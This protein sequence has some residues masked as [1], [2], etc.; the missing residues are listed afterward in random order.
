[1]ERLWVAKVLTSI[2]LLQAGIANADIYNSSY[3][4][5]EAFASV[6][7]QPTPPY[8]GTARIATITRQKNGEIYVL[9]LAKAIPL[10]QLK[11]KPSAGRLKIYGA[12]LITEKNERIPVKA[13]SNV[14]ISATDAAVPSESIALEIGIA[15][16]EIQAE[17]M[18]GD[19]ALDVKAISNKEIPQMT[20]REDLACKQKID[21][22]LKEKLDIVQRWAARIEGSA[23]G[24]IQEK[25]AIKEFNKYVN[26]FNSTLKTDKSS[27]ASTEYTL[28]LLNFFAERYNASRADSATEAAYKSMATETFGVLLASIQSELPCRTI[29]SEGLIN[30]ALDFQK[31]SD[32]AKADSRAGKLYNSMI[33]DISKV[34]PTQY[35]KELATKSYDFR[36]ADTE[37]NKYYKLF[38]ASKPESFL[39]GTH[40][41]MSLAAYAAAQQALTKEVLQMDNEKRYTLIVE[42]QAKYNDPDHFHQETM[43]K[44][45][46]IISEQGTLFRIDL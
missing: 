19:A 12:N 5:N 26:D 10:T 43:M 2:L 22:I 8:E 39:K 27:Y 14:T 15:A 17:A 34:I 44:Y 30:I 37:G 6:P 45:L 40:L 23:P 21:A 33:I 42:F 35:R 41:E 16:I 28:T 11:V 3:Q 31:R 29:S 13:L 9:D 46:M 32:D 36:Q 20:L 7:A 24:S 18:G 4:D 1:M 38:L 25:Y